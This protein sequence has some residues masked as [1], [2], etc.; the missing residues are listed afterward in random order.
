M[1]VNLIPPGKKYF[2][3][4]IFKKTRKK[5]RAIRILPE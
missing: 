1:P 2:A 5:K 3:S 4:G